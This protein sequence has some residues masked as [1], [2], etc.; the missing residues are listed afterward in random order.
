[1]L[2]K[3]KSS[4]S[5]LF[6]LPLR[7]G[8]NGDVFKTPFSKSGGSFK[9]F[10]MALPS[11]EPYKILIINGN[12]PRVVLGGSRR[13]LDGPRGALGRYLRFQGGP[14]EFWGG[15]RGVLA[16]SRGGLGRVV[17]GFRGVLGT[18]MGRP[19]VSRHL[20]RTSGA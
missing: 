9:L 10:T 2:E 4:L 18:L 5:T 14:G 6:F 17:G 19:G 20:L 8:I 7:A 3:T 11:T 16:T 13:V 15:S 12:G 1:M